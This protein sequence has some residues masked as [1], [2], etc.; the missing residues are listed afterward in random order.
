MFTRR[1]FSSLL[2]SAHSALALLLQFSGPAAVAQMVASN[3]RVRIEAKLTTDTDRKDLG[4]TTTDTVTQKKSITIKLS[5]KAKSPETRVVKWTAYGRDV[6]DND[7]KV[8]ESAELPLA[9]DKSGTQTVETKTFSS[10]YTPEHS[11]GKGGKGGKGG[12]GK[13]K[14]GGKK[15]EAE[16]TKFAGYAIQVK[17]GSQVV[18]EAS[19]PVGIGAK[20]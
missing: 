16:G 7:V 13:G 8:L 3:D 1:F 10:T 17:D 2:I 15:V 19:D 9:L 6:K 14:G 20:K 12:G 4:G 11:K 5:G 18:G